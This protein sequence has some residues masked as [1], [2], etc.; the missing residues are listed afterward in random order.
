[1]RNKKRSTFRRIV[2]GLVSLPI[3]LLASLLTIIYIVNIR[4]KEKADLYNNKLKSLTYGT[5]Y[6]KEYKRGQKK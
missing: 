6:T 3:N 5:V 4:A 2:F 1:M